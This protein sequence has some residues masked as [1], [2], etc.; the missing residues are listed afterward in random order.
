MAPESIGISPKNKWKI[1]CKIPCNFLRTRP[2]RRH[3]RQKVTLHILEIILEKPTNDR[4]DTKCYDFHV[5]SS[6]P[7][8]WDWA[9][10]WDALAKGKGMW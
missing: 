8:K 5:E 9:G 2:S 4:N 3:D 7:A 10:E 1:W 6:G